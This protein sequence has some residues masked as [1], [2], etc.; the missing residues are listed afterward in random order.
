MIEKKKLF[1]EMQEHLL[2]DDAPS[3]YFSR[4]REE[5]KLREHPFS[6]LERLQKTPQSPKHHP[7]GSVW[8][9]T[10]MVVDEAARKK[11]ESR[12]PLAFMWAA[13]LHDIGK[14]DTT[15]SEGE[16]VTAYNHEK[17]GAL[18]AGEFLGEFMEDKG[19]IRRI[20]ALIRWHMQILFVSKSMKFADIGS[21]VEDT[22][23]EEIALLGYCD[24][25]GR[26]NADRNA[27]TEHLN[28]FLEKCREFITKVT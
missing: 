1:E 5:G 11:R 14:A 8:N 3:I 15:R 6:M 25:M 27:E 19:L 18:Q 10:L 20:T 28:R 23:I 16:K 7:E 13:L 4:I 9:H 12:E 24:R 17:V 21:M 22:D 2:K 26:L